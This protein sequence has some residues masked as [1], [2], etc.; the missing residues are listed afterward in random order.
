MYGVK[1]DIHLGGVVGLY[2]CIFNPI[3]KYLAT[4]VQKT[5]QHVVVSSVA[6]YSD[7][8]L[9]LL[10]KGIVIYGVVFGILLTLNLAL[11]L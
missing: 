5:C 1:L 9:C 11:N 8:N 10:K 4:H 2:K 7:L 6:V 3:S